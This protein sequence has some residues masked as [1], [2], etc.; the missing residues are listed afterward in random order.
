M[1]KDIIKLKSVK[2]VLEKLPILSEE[3]RKMD[4]VEMNEW[5]K[6]VIRF[7]EASGIDYNNFHNVLADRRANDIV[8][9]YMEVFLA[10]RDTP[11]ADVFRELILGMNV[12]VDKHI[13]EEIYSAVMTINNRN[14][15]RFNEIFASINKEL[16]GLG[17]DKIDYSNV[18]AVRK[19]VSDKLIELEN[20]QAMQMEEI[21]R[22]LGIL[23]GGKFDT[24][25]SDVKKKIIES[26]NEIIDKI[27]L[28][29]LLSEISDKYFEYSSETNYVGLRDEVIRSEAAVADMESEQKEV[30]ALY[31]VLQNKEDSADR[32]HEKLVHMLNLEKGIASR[33]GEIRQRKVDYINGFYEK[34][35]IDI[36]TVL[37][38][39][40]IARGDDSML[41]G[42]FNFIA[43]PPSN[44]TLNSMPLFSKNK[45]VVPD[46]NSDEFALLSEIALGFA[47]KRKDI[48]ESEAKQR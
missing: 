26:A 40:G 8:N 47:K 11:D 23:R 35:N 38:S 31:T 43:L 9:R 22:F 1:E 2:G 15:N 10:N 12:D 36:D 28:L 41:F 7:Y 48:R 33:M 21:I 29:R 46:I 14:Q 5:L 32:K 30:D 6:D 34:C 13:M 17:I 44:E 39:L 45:L 24:Y 16:V 19:Q 37:A 25:N 20:A 27:V 4:Y 18:L 3:A 42:V